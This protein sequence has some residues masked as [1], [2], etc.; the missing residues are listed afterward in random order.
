M[1]IFGLVINRLNTDVEHADISSESCVDNSNYDVL[2][3][4]HE[5]L[6]SEWLILLRDIV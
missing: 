2:S 1:L 3:N 4:A 5:V 6:K